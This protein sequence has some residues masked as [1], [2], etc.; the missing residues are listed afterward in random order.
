MIKIYKKIILAGLSIIRIEDLPEDLTIELNE[1]I[2][3]A[4]SIFSFLDYADISFNDKII[5]IGFKGKFDFK[6]IT[7]LEKINRDKIDSFIKKLYEE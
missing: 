5:S 3:M 2:S 4:K 7:D 1:I 6:N